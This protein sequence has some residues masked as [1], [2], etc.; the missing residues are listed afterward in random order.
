VVI[1]DRLVSA[2]ILAFANP[3]ATFI[4]AGKQPSEPGCIDNDIQSEIFAWFLRLAHSVDYIVRLK[5]G[6]PM[7]LGRGGE[8]LDFLCRHGFEVEVVPGFQRPW[9]RLDLRGFP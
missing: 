3:D 4:Y 9:Q 5:N 6:D 8:E 7:V 1:Y 2:E